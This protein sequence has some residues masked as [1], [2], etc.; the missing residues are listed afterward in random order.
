MGLGF[1]LLLPR[2]VVCSFP[3]GC[4]YILLSAMYEMGWFLIL[5][6]KCVSSTLK[7]VLG[8]TD[9]VTEQCGKKTQP[10][11]GHIGSRHLWDH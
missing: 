10:L 11:K 5:E 9:H 8:R 4:R 1:S 6:R 2:A 7:Q 3:A